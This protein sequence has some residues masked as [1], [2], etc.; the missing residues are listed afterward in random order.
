MTH[1]TCRLTAKNWDQLQNLHSVIECGLPL[2][3]PQILWRHFTGCISLTNDL[4]H[5]ATF[6][7][8]R[9]ETWRTGW[10]L[11]SW[12][13]YRSRYCGRPVRS[14][15]NNS[16]LNNQNTEQLTTTVAVNTTDSIMNTGKSQINVHLLMSCI[17]HLSAWCS[18]V[19]QTTFSMPSTNYINHRDSNKRNYHCYCKLVSKSLY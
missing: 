4:P 17:P 8:T 6:K 10:F 13:L 19:V 2:S 12:I 15:I 1:V 18:N 7:R 3:W 16:A 14:R 5:D 11:P 9:Q